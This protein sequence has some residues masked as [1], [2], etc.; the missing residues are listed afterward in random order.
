MNEPD[1]LTSEE[2]PSCSEDLDA[3]AEDGLCSRCASA[4]HDVTLAML[5][6][7]H[8]SGASFFYDDE[9]SAYVM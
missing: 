1:F 8:D 5:A 7:P 6:I 9:P 4:L 3:E 2:C